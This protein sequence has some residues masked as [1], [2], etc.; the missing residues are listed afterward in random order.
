MTR[1]KRASPE[2]AESDGT[3][4]AAHPIRSGAA[5][6]SSGAR[7]WLVRAGPSAL[8]VVITLLAYAPTVRNGFVW[9]DAFIV[10]SNPDTRDLA[11][12]PRVLLSP[13]ET[14]PYYRPLNRASYLLDYQL[15]GMNPL[16]FHSVNLALHLAN[17]LALYAL[18]R[19]LFAT[20]GPAFVAALLMAVHPI[21]AEAVEFIT[22]RNNLLA[23]VF[24]LASLVLLIDAD[25]H[26]SWGR[27]CA[28][29]G[30]FLL[31]LLS[32]EPAAMALPLM[33]AWL[34]VP[35]LSG[36]G[37]RGRAAWLTPH[38]AALAIYLALRVVSLGG[39][40][41]VAPEASGPAAAITDRLLLNLWTIPRDLDLV[42]LPRG[43]AIF[44]VVE[45][46]VT[47]AVIV[48]WLGALGVAAA[49]L[50]RPSA[51]STLGLAWFVLNLAPISNLVAIPTSTLVAERYLYAPA[52]GLWLIAAD[53]VRR[54]MD[55]VGW[56]PVAIGVSA[57]TAVLALATAARA[58]D[59]RD[60]L[61]LARSAVQAE[62][63]SSEAHYN[64]GVALKDLG[65][66]GAARDAWETAS[67]L[68]PTHARAVAQLAT[69]AA[70]AGRLDEAEAGL[71]RAL[72]LDPRLALARY[73][74]AR[75]LDLAGRAGEAVEQYQA[76]LSQARSSA[77]AP[78][79][80]RA[81]E[82]LARLRSRSP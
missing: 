27:A 40:Q 58:L 66:L 45:R 26:A 12:L 44:H 36:R 43:L 33:A 54:A 61:S 55:R 80:P 50:A 9:D 52:V 70:V 74:L 65:D 73:N 14:P 11:A 68:D 78:Y 10:V 23:T 32:K 1:R 62:P 76:F 47:P 38:V 20:P 18:A 8:L 41:G 48:T 72:A 51:G 24:A 15:F 22:G 28:S 71:R 3:A 39:V 79:V 60:D 42:V 6:W 64:L 16:G 37:S 17:V 30:C 56:R 77:D 81:R 25:R 34:L 35:P 63:S 31:G 57:V 67:R 21:N 19:R 59:W 2:V 82:R 75:L 49:L 53:L 69:A 7:A 5:P 13:D 46:Q 4:H 29:A